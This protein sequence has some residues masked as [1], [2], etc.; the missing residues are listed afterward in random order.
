MPLLTKA[1]PN[2]IGGVSQQPDVTR[3][4]G[5]CEEQE[6]ALSSVVDGL[7]K[8]PQTKHI[9]EIISSEAIKTTS[10][11]HF[12]N[13]SA[14]EKYVFINNGTKL[15]VF[16]TLTGVEGTINGVQ[17]LNTSTV[18]YLEGDCTKLKGLTVGDS[19]FLLNQ[20]VG[21]A[22][23]SAQSNTLAN[24]AGVFVKQGDFGKEY[25]VQ[26]KGG[27]DTG[28][29]TITPASATLNV[30]MSRYVSSSYYNEDK[31]ETYYIYRHRVSAIT[32]VGGGEGYSTGST[33]S[34]TSNKNILTQPN[35]TIQSVTSSGAL[36]NSSFVIN[37][38]GDFEGVNPAQSSDEDSLFY[39]EGYLR[40]LGYNSPT[41]GATA[42]GFSSTPSYDA[43]ASI[44]SGVGTTGNDANNASSI[45][46]AKLL[47]GDTDTGETQLDEAAITG[48]TGTNQRFAVTRSNNYIDIQRVSNDGSSVTESTQDFEMIVSD[49]LSGTGLGAV[50]KTVGAISDLPKYCRNGQQIK[51][52]GASDDDVDDYYV[53]FQTADGA[54]FGIGSWIEDIGYSIAT[55]FNNTTMPHQLVRTDDNVFTLG[56]M[57]FANRTVGDDN[58][59]PMPSFVGKTITNIFLFKNRL[60]FLVED[61]II[62]SEAGLGLVENSVV[63]FNFFRTTVQQLL[64]SDPI[65][66]V[67]ASNKVVNLT[68]AVGFQENLILFA[69]NSQFVLKGGDL[70]TASTISI[71]PLTNFDSNASVSVLALGSYLYFPFVRGTFSGIREYTVNST[72][73]NYDAVEIT[74]H[75]PTFIP[76]D[77][78]LMKGSTSEN[79]L[80]CSSISQ[81]QTLFIYKYFWSGS[82]KLLSSW[83]K[84]TFD[85]EVVGFDVFE[86]SL[87]IVGTKENKTHLL[88]MPLQSGLKDTNMNYNTHL[89]MRKEHTLSNATSIPLGFTASVGDRVQVWDDQGTLLHDQTLTLASTSVTL[90]TA[91]TGTVFSGLSYMMKYVFSEQIFKEASGQSK[92]PSG[93]IRAQIR[94][95]VVF[96]NNTR[97]FKV[98]VKADNRDETSSVFTPVLVGTS[99]IGNIDLEDGH[100]KFPVFTDAQGTVITIENDSALPSNFSSA[101]FEMFVHRRSNRYG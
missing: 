4:E 20:T 94:N 70:L 93:F 76:S 69:E 97:G 77:L 15:R 44:T 71:A 68:D 81:P 58:T 46:I 34:F 37:S 2:L 48:G 33:L 89:D 101:E 52:I 9:A 72:T 91:H 25:T 57:T 38:G 83:S 63:N 11:I 3:F 79:F 95:G 64:D 49:G 43:T 56:S 88:S 54:D 82:K 61:N 65:D 30:T 90:S 96:F 21:V 55:S 62:L 100:F 8:R 67:V 86:G 47:K 42:L 92:A 98:K 78:K 13:R 40:H 23:N 39:S 75:I 6:N 85:F 53:K 73:D 80:V 87:F 59:N 66:V 99:T 35:I 50:F 27:V 24:R 36:T 12:I 41:V 22:I 16:N 7:A 74:E 51:I 10:F 14:N 19:T 60:G 32:V 5:Q 17:G 1:L 84:F 45:T 18:S 26:L 28:G 31:E 29:A